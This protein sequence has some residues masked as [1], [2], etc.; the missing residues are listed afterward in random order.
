MPSADA[1]F[2]D[3]TDTFTWPGDEDSTD[4]READFFPEFADEDGDGLA[5]PDDDGSADAEADGRAEG[6]AGAEEEG[7]ADA[8]D[9]EAG[10]FPCFADDPPVTLTEIGV[11]P[12]RV[13]DEPGVTTAEAAAGHVV[14]T[15]RGGCSF[16][17]DTCLP[18]TT[19]TGTG[20]WCLTGG[21]TAL[22]A[23]GGAVASIPAK[24]EKTASSSGITTLCIA[25]AREGLRR[26]GERR[27]I[28][29]PVRELRMGRIRLLMGSSPGQ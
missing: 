16:G 24:T 20:F 11:D 21:G 17:S 6:E 4:C 15:T 27:R 12:A 29:C 2:C 7:F 18:C 9:L 8:A 19:C 26:K 1:I 25:R 10:A 22:A 28:A 3:A 14:F 13:A 23:A 5:D